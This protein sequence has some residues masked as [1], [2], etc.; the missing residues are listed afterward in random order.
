VSNCTFSSNHGADLGGGMYNINGSSPTLTNCT[1][2]SNR[3]TYGGGLFNYSSSPTLTNCTFS[4]NSVSMTGG[5]LDNEVSSPTLINCTFFGNSAT[6]GGGMFNNQS[7]ATV[8]NCILWNDTASSSGSE[9]NDT[10]ASVTYSIVQGGYASGT[11]II[12]EDPLFVDVASGDLHLQS[13]S[14]AI[15]QG[16]DCSSVVPGTDKDGNARWDIASVT[17]APGMTGVDIGAYEFQ[18]Q[19]ANGDALIASCR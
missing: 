14:P 4:G 18:G 6:Y 2:S 16:A 1:F 11:H 17:N 9:F 19:S 3:A 10:S 7:S 8:T 13:S 5:G 15:D 12:S